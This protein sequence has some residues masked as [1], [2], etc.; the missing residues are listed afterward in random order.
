[1]SSQQLENILTDAIKVIE[2]DLRK[3]LNLGVNVATFT[4]WVLK[5][6]IIKQLQFTHITT[7]TDKEGNKKR[8]RKAKFQAWKALTKEQKKQVKDIIERRT[9]DVMQDLLNEY[10]NLNYSGVE[11]DV[12]G[13]AEKFTVTAIVI[14][15][16]K[17]KSIQIKSGKDIVIG[18]AFAGIRSGFKSIMNDLWAEI[19]QMVQE[20]S[21]IEEKKKFK[22][23]AFALEHKIG[24]SIAERRASAGASEL[25]GQLKQSLGSETK[26]KQFM[27]DLGLGAY[28]KFVSTDDLS[29]AELFIGSYS[30]NARQGRNYEQS[31]IAGIKKPLIEAAAKAAR[32]VA[33]E[34]W[35]GSDDRVTIEK[36]KIVEAFDNALT[37]KNKKSID[38]NRKLSKQTTR[39]K[40]IKTKT[41]VT[42]SKL[43]PLSLLTNDRTLKTPQKARTTNSA[44]S[45]I[46][47]K[48]LLNAKLPA[49]VRKNMN[50]PAL[51]NRTGRFAS[52][53]RVEEITETTQGFPSIGYSYRKN[54][55]KTFEPGGK[56]GSEQ[57]DPR[58]LID[59]S[60]REL[61]SELVVGRFYTRRV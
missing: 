19:G 22:K 13:T 17:L 38:T 55:Y 11:F 23:G 61:A 47:L 30:K 10:K 2:R 33:I 28:I 20:L 16:S 40:K 7:S 35:S 4:P 39:T 41:K 25:Y 27:R 5:D 21:G 26:V 54:P 8:T 31:L 42:R 57:R 1:M 37:V 24:S 6:A 9:L 46:T 34:G 32:G 50:S 15:A 60:I 52:S 18:S 51:V 45:L 12:Q 3:E 29:K 56:L 53:V 36:K 44:D 48:A 59:R 43:K 49:E 14:D 58:K